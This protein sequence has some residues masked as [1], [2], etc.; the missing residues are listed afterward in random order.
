LTAQKK[1]KASHR[2]IFSFYP[3]PGEKR[4]RVP[5]LGFSLAGFLYWLAC[6]LPTRLDRGMCEKTVV[7]MK[8]VKVKISQGQM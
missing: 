4:D 7:N 5:G 6:L 3:V 8:I 2:I 1:K